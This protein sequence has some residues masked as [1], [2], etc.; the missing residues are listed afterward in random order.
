MADEPPSPPLPQQPAPS[1]PAARTDPLAIV[2]LVLAILS[3][4]SCLLLASIP[5]IICGHKARSRI[6]RSNGTL[7]GMNFAI[8]ALIIAYLEIPFGV[9]GGI[10]LVDMIRS[11]RVRLKELAV[12]QKEITSEDGKLKVTTSGFWV[13]RTDL[14]KRASLQASRKDKELYVIVISYPKSTDSPMTLEQRHQTMRDQMTKDMA[15]SSATT[16]VSITIDEH[17]ALQDEI[18]GTQKDSVLTFLHST[19][20]DGDSFHQILA[21][22]LK[23]RWDANKAELAD[24]TSSFHSEK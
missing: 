2:S 12:Q 21:W 11:E 3:W 1:P 17:P 19:V 5:A 4:I 13:Q 14:N 16:P 7:G 20:D 22:T 24:V 8:A 10:M 15:N 6:R 9:L 18:T 23:S